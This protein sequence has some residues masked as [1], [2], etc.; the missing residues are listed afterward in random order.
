MKLA[1]DYWNEGWVTGSYPYRYQL[2]IPT[3]LI[4][5]TVFALNFLGDWF[6]DKLDPKLR[7]FES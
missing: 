6:R 2:I 3:T 4:V 5:M 1:S 7:Q